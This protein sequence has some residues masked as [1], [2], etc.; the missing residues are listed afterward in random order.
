MTRIEE[1]EGVYL[2]DADRSPETISARWDEISRAAAYPLQDALAQTRKFA[3]LAS[4]A[5]GTSSS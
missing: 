2:E 4:L 1:T 5:R 3:A